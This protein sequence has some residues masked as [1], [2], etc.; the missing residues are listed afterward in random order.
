MNTYIRIVAAAAALISGASCSVSIAPL[1]SSGHSMRRGPIPVNGLGIPYDQVLYGRSGGDQN[2][3]SLDWDRRSSVVHIP[4]SGNSR[5]RTYGG[6][7]TSGRPTSSGGQG[8][9]P[10]GKAARCDSCGVTANNAPFPPFS[11]Q[12]CGAT[13]LKLLD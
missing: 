2:N 13:V 3:G 6:S 11:C 1:G 12:R 10:S 4:I 9:R 8:L 7:P 5:N